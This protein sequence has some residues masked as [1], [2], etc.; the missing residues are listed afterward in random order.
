MTLSNWSV[1]LAG[2][3][4]VEI[5]SPREMSISS[6]SVRVMDWP[7]V[8]VGQITVVRDD[9]RNL[10][11]LAGRLHAY[12]IAHGEP[13]RPQR[14]PS[15]AAKIEVG[16]V[17]PLDRKPKCGVFCMARIS[18]IS[19]RFEVAHQHVLPWYQGMCS[20][21]SMML[22]PLNADMRNECD[23]LQANLLGESPS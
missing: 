17:D 9:S 20:L 10:A 1:V 7:A 6:S 15:K 11:F 21:R 8:A 18:S 12:A 19:T 23:A 16:P 5:T 4:V 2:A 3:S 22:S 14:C 13:P